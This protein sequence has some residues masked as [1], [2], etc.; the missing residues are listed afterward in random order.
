MIYD[1]I[2]WD[3]HNLEHA[4]KR[5]TATEIEQAILNATTATR[6]R[7]H[8][9]RRRIRS[10]T[11]GGKKVLVIAANGVRPVTGWKE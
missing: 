4:T 8:P 5:L 7:T 2:D 6:S 3:E 10:H 11:D 9:D 1:H